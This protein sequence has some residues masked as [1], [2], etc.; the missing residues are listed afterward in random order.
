MKKLTLEEILNRFENKHDNRYNYSK[1]IYTNIDNPSIIICE[2]H[3][4]FLQS[5]Y[6]HQNGAGCIKCAYDNYKG[7]WKFSHWEEASKTSKN[8][9]GYKIYFLALQNNEER[10]FKIG[11]TFLPINLRLSKNI[12]YDYHVLIE[13][14][15]NTAIECC[16]R[17]S[18]I[19]NN[20]KEFQYIP[21]IKFNGYNEYYRLKYNE[22]DAKIL[23]E[24]FNLNK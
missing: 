15:F 16:N 17:E 9:D 19:H 14:Q 20:L 6:N 12:P 23:I 7:S 8:F 21:K 13:L 5:A 18:K 3:G 4:E 11:R 22:N 2:K 1:F 10:F 24:L